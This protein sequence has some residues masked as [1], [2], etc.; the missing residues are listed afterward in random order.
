MG[1]GSGATIAALSPGAQSVCPEG[2]V[3]W[4][5][6]FR[7]HWVLGLSLCGQLLPFFH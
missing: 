3:L 5:V 7:S 6:S 4:V 1:E 2:G